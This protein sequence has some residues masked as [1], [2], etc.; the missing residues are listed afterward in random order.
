MISTASGN[1]IEANAVVGNTNGIFVGADTRQ[2][3]VRQNTILGNPA[4]QI[5]NTHPSAQGVDIR[6]LAP[7][8]AVTFERNLCVTSVNAPCPDVSGIAGWRPQQLP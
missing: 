7:A 3:L 1:V 6:S 4:I 8:G 5:G 2:T